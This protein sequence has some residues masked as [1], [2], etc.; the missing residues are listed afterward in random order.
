MPNEN[1]DPVTMEEEEEQYEGTEEEAESDGAEAEPGVDDQD[2][3]VDLADAFT[4]VVKVDAASA[5]DA[6]DDA[7]PGES[8]TDASIGDEEDDDAEEDAL[9]ADDDGYDNYRGPSDGTEE[10]AYA[11]DYQGAINQVATEITRASR[12]QAAKEFAD[13][14]IRH[15]T[16]KDLY[17]RDDS[18]NVTFV[19]PDDRSRPFSSRMEAQQWIDSINKEIDNEMR[20]RSVEIS[21][22][23]Q[24]AAAPALRLLKFAPTYDAM[25]DETKRMFDD[26][27][28]DYEVKNS[29]G[30]VV[31]YNCDLDKMARKAERIAAKYNHTSQSRD[32][33]GKV[34][35]SGPR[36]SPALDTRTHGTSS[37]S[38]GND[39]PKTMEEAMRK[40]QEMNR[41]KR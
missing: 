24:K 28:E 35:K 6:V 40:V 27:I 11:P 1:I 5:D 26:L 12:Q 17:R 33:S 19:N 13:N 30:K 18:G 29:K 41:S 9:S 39:E 2:E 32:D 14:G 34:R 10:P 37:G 22:G 38:K 21:K 20:K 16:M 23:I 15:F 4:R 25:P 3:P 8:E 36:K 7:E 31:G